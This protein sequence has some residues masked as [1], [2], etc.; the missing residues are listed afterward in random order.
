MDR[1]H[2]AHGKGVICVWKFSSRKVRTFRNACVNGRIVSGKS[3][4]LL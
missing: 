1:A 4:V 2:S 3:C